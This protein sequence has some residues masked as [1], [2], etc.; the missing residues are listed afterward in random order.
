MTEWKNITR[1]LPTALEA[2]KACTRYTDDGLTYLHWEPTSRDMTDGL[3]KGPKLSQWQTTKYTP[4]PPNGGITQVGLKVGGQIPTGP[5]AGLWLCYV[6]I[7]DPGL[8][9]LAD[10]RLPQTKLQGGKETTP[11]AHKFF[12]TEA[13]INSFTWSG[14]RSDGVKGTVLEL[15]GVTHSGTVGHQVVVAPSAHF[16]SNTRYIWDSYGPPTATTCAI[17]FEA[18]KT[19]AMGVAACRLSA[20]RGQ[21]PDWRPPKPSPSTKTLEMQATHLQKDDFKPSEA[22]T[23]SVDLDAAAISRLIGDCTARCAVLE[24]GGRQ[25]GLNR[26]VFVTASVLSG[27]NA[28]EASFD[29]LR[30]A[31]VDL[32]DKMPPPEVNARVW[33]NST[34]RAITQGRANPRRRAGLRKYPLSIHGLADL[35][36]DEWRD[37]YRYV[38]EWKTWLRWNGLIWE[39]VPCLEDLVR[40]MVYILR[41]AQAEASREPDQAFKEDAFK[42]YYKCESSDAPHGAEK[43]LRSREIAGLGQG[44]CSRNLD[45]DPWLFVCANGYYDIRTGTLHEAKREDYVTMSSHYRY[46]PAPSDAELEALCPR[47]LRHIDWIFETEGLEDGPK[48]SAYLASWL[49]YAMTGSNQEQK[50]LILYGP[51]CN[52]KSALLDVIHAVSGDYSAKLAKEVLIKTKTEARNSDEVAELEGKRW[53][54][55]SETD[56][57]D[58]LSEGRIKTLTGSPTVRAMRKFKG[59]AEFEMRTTL[60]LDTNHAPRIH[61]REDATLRRIKMLPFF[62]RVSS[63]MLVKDWWRVVVRDEG[64]AVLTWLLR[65]AH[66]YFLRDSLAPEPD[67]VIRENREFA[68]ENDA[69]GSFLVDMCITAEHPVRMGP[70][71]PERLTL[72]AAARP[73]Y[74]C[75]AKW[76]KE[77]GR[78]PVGDNV[79]RKS[80]LAREFTN[81]RTS[82]AVVWMGLRLKP[83]EDTEAAEKEAT[84]D[85]SKWAFASN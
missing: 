78:F 77:S 39:K 73:L 5:C 6:D 85:A 68:A 29:D 3:G 7:D 60:I 22:V 54:F 33:I 14:I 56:P 36:V 58:F 74:Q 1:G 26:L 59:A 23:K 83:W 30:N 63:D 64:D 76:A 49:G 11:H 2:N 70:H 35:L 12:A 4:P 61:G 41:W 31:V 9:I 13:P 16:R 81:R 24:G 50:L 40:D 52:G 57:G 53:G 38:Y 34:D 32:A 17:L 28:P 51:G 66:A 44:V 72:V 80:L 82:A 48:A 15:F 47:F 42:W 69:I 10:L 75:Y 37:H 18:C 21:T 43:H 27:G 62:N 65:Q 45:R 19:L 79:F 84:H 71:D 20:G 8:Q 67:C 55:F 46:L 25:A